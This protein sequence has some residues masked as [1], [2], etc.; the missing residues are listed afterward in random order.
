MSDKLK[1]LQ[2]KLTGPEYAT[3]DNN[4]VLVPQSSALVGEEQPSVE[5]PREASAN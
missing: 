1:I 2:E 5:F 3:E 4:L